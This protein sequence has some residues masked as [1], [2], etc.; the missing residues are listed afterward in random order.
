MTDAAQTPQVPW[1]LQPGYEA[2]ARRLLST[3]FGTD[4]SNKPYTGAYFEALGGGGDA[5][6]HRDV[7]TPVDI[8]AVSTLSVDVPAAASIALL[9]PDADRVSALL[10]GIP[11]DV[12]L[13]D[14]DDALISEA[15]PAVQLWGLLRGYKGMGR[16]KTSKLMARKRPRLV[17]IFDSV[18]ERELGLNGSSGHWTGMREVLRADDGALHRRAVTLQ[19]TPGVG[20]LISPLRVIDVVV[21]MYGKDHARSERWA[22]EEGP[23]TST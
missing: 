3:Y 12:D 1:V 11:D 9:G 16:T 18:V 7:I 4:G 21:W 22:H 10:S 8:V 23:A 13:V 19:D 15:S 17:P 5:P 20:P 6:A 2:V 14:A